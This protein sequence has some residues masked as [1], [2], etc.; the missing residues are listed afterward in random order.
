M[1]G[2]GRRARGVSA[3]ERRGKKEE[4]SGRCCAAR[5]QRERGLGSW[6]GARCTA[7]GWWWSFGPPAA[8]ALLSRGPK[9][10]AM[11][12]PMRIK[13]V[14]MYILG[15][16]VCRLT[17]LAKA[18]LATNWS[19]SSGATMDAGAKANA[20]NCTIEARKKTAVPSLHIGEVPPPA[21]AWPLACRLL[22]MLMEREP[23]HPRQIPSAFIDE[24]LAGDEES[25]GPA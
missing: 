12:V 18:R 14:P 2:C 17:H 13:T 23:M 22:P 16:M 10:T 1:H 8:Y 6:E 25:P 5:R 11:T 19:D 9:L 20:A 7:H 24:L 4:G 15:V 21:S 3:K